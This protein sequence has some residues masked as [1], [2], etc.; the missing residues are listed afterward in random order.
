[1]GEP[2]KSQQSHSTPGLN[3]STQE[4]DT[5]N[6]MLGLRQAVPSHDAAREGSG[7]PKGSERIVDS[8]LDSML[9]GQ[10]ED[11]KAPG[12]AKIPSGSLSDVS[13]PT[14]SHPVSLH[15]NAIVEQLLKALASELK[16]CQTP[17]QRSPEALESLIQ[18]KILNLISCTTNDRKRSSDQAG[19]DEAGRPKKRV[20]CQTCDKTMDRACDMK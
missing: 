14:S 6:I 20:S 15:S 16:A 8:S 12:Q 11:D 9:A 2:T 17:E 19:L 18:S 3:N 7:T 5:A 10:V 4:L 13:T 1:M